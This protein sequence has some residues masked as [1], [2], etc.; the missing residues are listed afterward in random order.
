MQIKMEFRRVRKMTASRNSSAL[1][2]CALIALQF[3]CA[4]GTERRVT[5]GQTTAGELQ[6]QLGPALV[7]GNSPSRPEAELRSYSECEY[8]L[9]AE[10]VVARFCKPLDH[11]RTVQY[12][13][14][15]WRDQATDDQPLDST[16]D[17]HGPD[18]FLLRLRQGN[19]AVVFSRQRQVVLQVI[20]YSNRPSGG[21]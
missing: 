21:R 15:L 19:R 17:P 4:G 20:D 14:Q 3:G 5:P 2:V 7:V 1:L 18:R 12:W 13:R 11:E 16:T 8:Q 10:Q 9:E 6:Q